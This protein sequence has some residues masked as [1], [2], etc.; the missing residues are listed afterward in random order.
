MPLVIGVSALGTNLDSIS[1]VHASVTVPVNPQTKDVVIEIEVEVPDSTDWREIESVH[2]AGS[3]GARPEIESEIAASKVPVSAVGDRNA[4]IRSIKAESLTY[5]TRG[6]CRPIDRSMMAVL[7]VNSIS[8]RF[9]P[10]DHS[11]RRRCARTLTKAARVI[12]PRHFSVAQCAIEHFDLIN[13]SV[14]ITRV[15]GIERANHKWD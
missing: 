4:V 6:K 8:F 7:S 14:E 10:R 15:A 3:A 5:F 12:N 13:E 1:S 9:P 2:P 11:I